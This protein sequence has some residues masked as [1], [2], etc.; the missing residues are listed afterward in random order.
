MTLKKSVLGS[1]NRAAQLPFQE[2]CEEHDS[3]AGEAFH[4]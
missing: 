4:E 1:E 3:D 2:T